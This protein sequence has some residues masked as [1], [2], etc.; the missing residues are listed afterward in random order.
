MWHHYGSTSPHLTIFKARD[1][2]CVCFSLPVPK[3]IMWPDLR[4]HLAVPPCTVKDSKAQ[5][6]DGCS[7][8]RASSALNTF[9]GRSRDQKDL[10]WS[11]SRSQPPL[12][13]CCSSLCALRK[14]SHGQTLEEEKNME[15]KQ[16]RVLSAGLLQIS[17]SEHVSHPLQAPLTCNCPDPQIVKMYMA[18]SVGSCQQHIVASKTITQG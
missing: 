12:M 9:D 1:W 8:V 6:N 14:I 18:V 4:S 15:K 17:V 16:K 13:E 3:K 11:R 7:K 2:Q 5:V 10:L